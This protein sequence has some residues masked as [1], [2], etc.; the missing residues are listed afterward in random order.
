MTNIIIIGLYTGHDVTFTYLSEAP[1]TTLIAKDRF[2]R[3]NPAA[4]LT[5]F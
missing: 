5:S 3:H 4:T 2:L 1:V